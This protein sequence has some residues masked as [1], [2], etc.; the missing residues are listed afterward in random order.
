MLGAL[1]GSLALA[2]R[3]RLPYC[4]M[5]LRALASQASAP[6]LLSKS[7][8]ANARASVVEDGRQ[9]RAF[10]EKPTVIEGDEPNIK[11]DK[12]RNENVEKIA[13][14]I[15]KL[16]LIEVAELTDVLKEK[17]GINDELMM[18]QLG[19]HYGG[20]VVAAGGAGGEEPAAAEEKTA[21]DVKLESFDAAKKLKVIK[22]VRALTGLGLKEAKALVESAPSD[23]KLGVSKEE[24]EEIQ[25]KLEEVGGKIKID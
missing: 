10:C 9:I 18:Q 4:A 24:A 3:T 8:A 2:A 20:P 25:K 6:S 16:S 17:L 22:E 19:A 13:E 7:P 21:F 1:R 14:E 23:V 11:Y 15:L 12:V 5:E